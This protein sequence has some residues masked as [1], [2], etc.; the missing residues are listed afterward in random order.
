MDPMSAPAA[1]KPS[2]VLN[3][4]H[5]AYDYKPARLD[6][7]RSFMMDDYL[8]AGRFARHKPEGSA[9]SDSCWQVLNYKDQPQFE[10]KQGFCETKFHSGFTRRQQPSIRQDE[11]RLMNESARVNTSHPTEDSP[12]VSCTGPA[13][14]LPL[15][16]TDATRSRA[17]PRRLAPPTTCAFP[18]FGSKSGQSA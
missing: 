4:S 9:S 15:R 5:S 18:R 1:G 16:R 2:T 17:G 6:R 12:A 14:E 8:N 10:T 11:Q 7:H 13:H 3:S